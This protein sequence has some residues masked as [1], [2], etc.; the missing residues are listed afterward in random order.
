MDNSARS[1]LDLFSD[2]AIRSPEPLWQ[3]LRALGAVVWMTRYNMW[4]VPRY[5]EVKEV[6]GDWRRFTTARGVAMDDKVNAATSGPGKANSLTSDPPLHDEIR[7]ITGIPLMPGRL[8]ELEQPI[9]ARVEA[10]VDQLCQRQEIDAM[11]DVAKFIP[12]NMVREFVGLPSHGQAEMLAWA[13]ATFDAMGP[14][15]DRGKKAIPKIQELH[16]FCINEAIPPNLAK[17]GWADK[18]YQAADAGKIERSQCP[19][20]MREYI[21]PALDTTIFGVGHLLRQLSLNPDQWQRLKDDRELI[22]SAINETLRLHSPINSFTRFVNEDTTIGSAQVSAGDRLIVLYGSA[23][24]CEQ[25][26][27]NPETFNIE[28][29]VR[30]HLAFGFGIHSCGGMHLARLEM[31]ILL[32][33]MLD[34]IDHFTTGTPEVF[35]N[36]TLKG[37]K[38]MPMSIVPATPPQ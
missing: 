22:G 6:L 37:F 10:H 7:K 5:A 27:D 30:D 15:N 36:N 35:M 21:G 32:E 33:V 2:A 16:Q 9:R 11:E 29:N 12:M 18:I 34:K 20:L 24:R 3:E 38:S 23:N 31:R 14:M 17:D 13:A 8:R 4:A 28:R 26:W 25:K 19:G 1:D